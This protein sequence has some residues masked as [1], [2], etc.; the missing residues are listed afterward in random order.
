M[1]EPFVIRGRPVPIAETLGAE[2]LSHGEGRAA[3]R[4]PVH[5]D[6]KNPVGQLQGGMY[7]VMMDMAMAIAADGIAT[8]S[9]QASGAGAP[10]YER[11]GFI[12]VGFIE[13]W[14]RREG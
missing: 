6:Y 14:E 5:D 11:L 12:D 10:L 9:L 4:F 13:L 7:G 8:A 1:S 3:I 2:L